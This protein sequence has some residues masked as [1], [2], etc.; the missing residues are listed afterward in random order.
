MIL[1]LIF[2]LIS[3]IIFTP[4]LNGIIRKNLSVIS[5]FEKISKEELRELEQRCTFFNEDCLERFQEISDDH[6]NNN[7]FF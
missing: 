4:I 1:S 3:L 2:I 6:E 7:P 5:Y